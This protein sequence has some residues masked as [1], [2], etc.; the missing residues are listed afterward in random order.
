VI[1]QIWR[2]LHYAARKLH[3]NPGFT[4]V[5]VSTLA[6]GIGASTAIFSVVDSVLLRALPFENPD[7]LNVILGVAGPDRDVR[8]GSWPEIRDWETLTRSFADISIYAETTLNL[9]GRGAAETLEGEIVS[10]GYFR[11]LGVSPH[12]GR[13]L[14]PE[15]DVP[16]STAKVVISHALWQ[17][18]FGGARDVLGRTIVVDDRPA[19]IV[20]VMPEGFRGLSFDTQ[21]W[22]TLLPFE[23]DAGNDRGRRWL[24]A[25]GRLR[26]GASPQSAQ[27]DIR[28]AARQLEDQYPDSNW[29][30]SADLVSLREFYLGTTRMLLLVVLGAVGFLMLIACVN[31]IN[32][33]ITRGIGRRGEVALRYAL[34]AG[35]Q[36]VVRQFTTEAVALAILGGAVGVLIAW[37]GMQSLISMIP[38]GIVPGYAQAS[39]NGRVLLFAAGIVMVAGILSGVV[40][41][42]RSTRHGLADGL[43]MPGSGAA[44]GARAGSSPLLRMLVAVEVALAVLL[45]GGAALM[46]RSLVEQL[47]VPPGFESENV[48]VAGVNLTGG[49]YTGAARVR[50]ATQLVE[51][52]ASSAGVVSVAIG[53]DAPLRGNASAS[54]LYAEGRPDDRVRYYRHSVTPGYFRTLGIRMIRGRSF[55]PSDDTDAPPVVIVSEAFARKLWPGRDAIGQYVRIGQDDSE[56]RATVVG[57]AGN[58]RFR[59]LTS[60][61]F[62]PAEDPDVYF[63]YAQMPTGSLEVL[64]RSAASQLVAVDVMQRA[65]AELDPSVPLASPQALESVLAQQTG[66]ARFGSVI[67]GLFAVLALVLCGIGLYGIMAFFVVS[68]RSEIAIRM[69]LGARQTRVLAMVV[70][71]GMLL[72]GIGVTAGL[73]AVLLGGRLFSNLFYGVGAADPLVHLSSA[74]LLAMI[75]FIA[76]VLPAWRA[77]RIDPTEAIRHE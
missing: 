47:A 42:L 67:L 5:A 28:N 33:Q 39:I 50:F 30:R 23:P 40:P 16:N 12:L 6:L 36:R 59:D 51:T 76:C 37:V 19:L 10:P 75:A 46:V 8:G 49:E 21:I 62:S 3:K 29:E 54:V 11:L 77:T 45:I 17:E 2:D 65:L 56:Y 35:R 44:P 53:S 73:T 69:A 38:A 13:G 71:Q 22:T 25:I 7:R 52:L 32:L 48:L 74:A 4:V 41:A 68:R 26:G 14:L 64:V 31:V 1:S 63:A 55:E 66:N 57:V 60:D 27:A 34:G 24:T 18:R 15:D 9:S 58:V 72:V 70:R 20:G 43:R 61:L